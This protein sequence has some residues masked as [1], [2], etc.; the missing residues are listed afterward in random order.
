MMQRED[1]TL[2]S[3]LSVVSQFNVMDSETG[4]PVLT[5]QR[6]VDNKDYVTITKFEEG[7]EFSL[8]LTLDEATALI[9]ALRKYVEVT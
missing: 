8:H 9:S 5:V 7:D 1:Y 3:I 6:C 2:T 4:K